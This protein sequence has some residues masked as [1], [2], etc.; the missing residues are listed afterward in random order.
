MLFTPNTSFTGIATLVYTNT[1]NIGG[2]NSGLITVTV[3]TVASIPLN[4]QVLG[5]NIIMSWNNSPFVFSLQRATNIAGPW[6]TVPG[7]TPPYTNRTTTNAA[8]FFRLLH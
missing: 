7:V 3:G 8:G 5:T 2:M 1:D 4:V 6:I